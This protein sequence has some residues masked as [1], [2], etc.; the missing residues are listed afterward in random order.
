MVAYLAIFYLAFNLFGSKISVYVEE[1]EKFKAFREFSIRYKGAY[2]QS[3]VILLTSSQSLHY[4]ATRIDVSLSLFKGAEAHFSD[5]KNASDNLKESV[6]SFM[7]YS[8][9]SD[10]ISL[11]Y[12]IS[13]D[14]DRIVAEIEKSNE[15]RDKDFLKRNI[16]LLLSRLSKLNHLLKTESDL[17]SLSRR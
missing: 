1:Y 3:E 17:L 12:Q 4:A 6:K 8:V 14:I 5:F 16:V 13:Q 2:T 9:D 7:G 15:P 11:L 10:V